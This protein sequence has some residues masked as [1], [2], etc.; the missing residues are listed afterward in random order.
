[1]R[2][3]ST[4]A[5]DAVRLKDVLAAFGRRRSLRDPMA[6]ACEELDLT[7]S[8]IH[9]LLWLRL[10]GPL[11]MGEV[12]RRLGSSLKTITGVVDR[13]VARRLVQR[14]RDE[15]DRRVVRCKLTRLGAREAD[16][17]DEA[18]TVAME[19]VLGLI[20]PGDRE[21]LIRILENLQHRMEK[22][23]AETEAA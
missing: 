13:L 12:A 14:E 10:D 7:H 6:A 17:L 9:A 22:A 5:Q 19:F 8:Q 1:M 23:A 21:H 2:T 11:T 16:K 18:T 4:P 3:I 15:H 20:E